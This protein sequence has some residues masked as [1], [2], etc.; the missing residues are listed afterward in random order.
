MMSPICDTGKTIPSSIWNRDIKK[1]S[2]VAEQ[3][4]INGAAICRRGLI[5]VIPI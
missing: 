1:E 3:S 4:N 2:Y 5:G